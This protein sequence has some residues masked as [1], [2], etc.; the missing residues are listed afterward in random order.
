MFITYISLSRARYNNMHAFV[1]A[2]ALSDERFFCA[3]YSYYYFFGAVAAAVGSA[4]PRGSHARGSR[5]RL[6]CILSVQTYTC[7][8][9]CVCACV[10][11]I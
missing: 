2:C 3:S 5:T 6:V 9:V 7:V 4:A 11:V 8:W 1:Y 10:A